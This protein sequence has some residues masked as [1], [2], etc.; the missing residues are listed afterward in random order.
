[1]YTLFGKVEKSKYTFNYEAMKAMNEGI[2]MRSDWVIPICNGH[3][4]LKNKDGEKELSP[5]GKIMLKNGL[6][7]LTF[8]L[9]SYPLWKYFIFAKK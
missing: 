5:L 9:I 6:V 3:E 8:N 4:R 7:F 2:Q 1:M